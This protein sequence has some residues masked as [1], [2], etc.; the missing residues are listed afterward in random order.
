[1][2]DTAASEL[3]AGLVSFAEQTDDVVGISDAWGRLLYLNPAACKLMGVGSAEGLTLADVFPAASFG[4]F[5]DVARPELLRRGSWS[6]E[7]VAN[8]A[9]SRAVRLGVSTTMHLGPGGENRGLVLIG[10]VLGVVDERTSEPTSHSDEREVLDRHRFEG[11]VASVVHAARADGPC[12]VV[13][14]DLSEAAAAASEHGHG[15]I[16]DQIMRATAARLMRMT[17]TR[18]S[19][20]VLSEHQFA[21]LVRGVRSRQD[22]LRV[23]QSIEEELQEPPVETMLGPLPLR[24]SHGVAF[25]TG[26]DDPVEL[27][28]AAA[29]LEPEIDPTGGHPSPRQTAEQEAPEVSAIAELQLA[30][31]HGEIKAY[32]QAVVDPR[33]R[34]LLG[35][36]GFA[37]WHHR[38]KGVLGPGT[39]AEI[40]AETTL[41]PVIDLYVARQTATLLIFETRDT[42]LAQYT[43]ASA[44]LLLDDHTEQ[45]FD[46]IAAAYFLAMHQLHVTIDARTVTESAQSLRA[47]L[48][49]LADADLS[50]VLS[51]VHDPG[52]DVD[53][54]RRLGFRALELSPQLLNDIGVRPALHYAVADLAERAHAADLLVSA[55]GISNEQQHDTI[56]RLRCDLASGDLYAPARL[57]EVIAD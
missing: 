13:V 36:R 32:A 14:F 40:A 51:D 28:R 18:E 2:G 23:A 37:Q 12:A 5:Y 57:T 39:I 35:Y 6:G 8:A 44:R 27:V 38:T 53:D 17:H 24:V 41:A 20:G 47:A 11:E 21:V 48:R 9:G 33:S 19:V 34:L 31:S 4:V 54:L 25:S 26:D 45:R 15:M 50:L 56:L 3:V 43:P 55:T 42:A 16:V 7:V 29:S 52:V 22:A 10:R 49:S 1:V 46:E 30:F